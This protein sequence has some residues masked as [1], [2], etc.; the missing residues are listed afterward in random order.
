VEQRFTIEVPATSDAAG[1][2]RCRLEAVCDP[3]AIVEVATV[4]QPRCDCGWSGDCTT[5]HDDARAQVDYH[6]DRVLTGA[7]LSP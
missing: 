6:R 3:T 5:D 7:G 2:G 1:A 4:Y